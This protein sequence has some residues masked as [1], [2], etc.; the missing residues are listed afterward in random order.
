MQQLNN[1]AF[2]F[3]PYIITTALVRLINSSICVKVTELNLP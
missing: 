3:V 2:V 1:F